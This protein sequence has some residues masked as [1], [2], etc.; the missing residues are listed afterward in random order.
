MKSINEIIEVLRDCK[1]ML[2]EKYG[3]KEIGGLRLLC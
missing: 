3:V 2:K 1:R